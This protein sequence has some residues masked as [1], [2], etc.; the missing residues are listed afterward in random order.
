[1]SCAVEPPAGAQ[2]APTCL[3]P[4]ICTVQEAAWPLHW[5]P[6]PWNTLPAAGVWKTVSVDPVGTTQAQDVPPL[7]LPQS[8]A[9]P[10][11]VGSG[12]LTSP[13]SPVAARPSSAKVTD[14]VLWEVPDFGLNSATA[15][16]SEPEPRSHSVSV[17][18][19][20]SPDQVPAAN[21]LPG[22]AES[23]T[24]AVLLNA[25]H[26]HGHGPRGCGVRSS[27]DDAQNQCDQRQ[28]WYDPTPHR[29]TPSPHE[30]ASLDA[31]PRI[32]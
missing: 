1:V 13:S 3:S 20:Q 25:Q 9:L 27:I 12:A 17:E 21:P 8:I 23:T 6:Q 22:F 28:H 15:M 4:F 11:G 19:P 18:P 14:N 32:R 5:P 29:F 2:A 31:I 16:L 7:A 26:L 10:G 30:G 24:S